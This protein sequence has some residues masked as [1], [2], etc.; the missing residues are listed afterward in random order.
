M[1]MKGK[2]IMTMKNESKTLNDRRVFAYDIPSGWVTYI[3]HAVTGVITSIVAAVITTIAAILV[4]A[5]G[6]WLAYTYLPMRVFHIILAVL[7]VDLVLGI[8]LRAVL[9]HR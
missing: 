5:G 2:I 8:V 4:L 7:G 9:S 3:T 6:L 1:P